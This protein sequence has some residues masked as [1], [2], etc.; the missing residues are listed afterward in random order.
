MQNRSHFA[1]RLHHSATSLLIAAVLVSALC[2]SARGQDDA[3]LPDKLTEPQKQELDFF[4]K[5]LKDKATPPDRRIEAA[6]LL[7]G[8][9]WKQAED[10]L[11]EVLADP[12]EA[13]AGG[14]LAVLEALASS[15]LNGNH[16]RALD[17]FIEPLIAALGSKEAAVQRAAARA[18]VIYKGKE[19][20]LDRLKKLVLSPDQP[21]A[22]RRGIVTAFSLM[23][24]TQSSVRPLIQLL[25][26][27]DAGLRDLSVSALDQLI[28]IG[29]G[30][31]VD[32]WKTWWQANRYNSPIEWVNARLQYLGHQTHE[33]RKQAQ[34]LEKRLVESLR[35]YYLITPQGQKHDRVLGFL[36][37]P[38][39][40]VR[41]LGLQLL[42]QMIG[43][44]E[45]IPDPLKKPAIDRLTDDSPRVRAAAADVA[46]YL[47]EP[48]MDEL[49]MAQLTDEVDPDAR[50]MQV[51]ALGRLRT[52]SAVPLL[53]KLLN[54][55]ADLA[56]AAESA[57]ALGSI[58]ARGR[59]DDPGIVKSVTDA[60][61]AR[62]KSADVRRVALREAI[63]GAMASIA[64]AA[65]GP[66]L[67]TALTDESAAVRMAAVRG[68]GNMQYD[69]AGRAR[70]V[71]ALVTRLGAEPDRGVRLALLAS[72]GRMGPGR[73][74][75]DAIY[76][77]TNSTT[78]A[79]EAVR[80]GAWETLLSLLKSADKATQLS[81]V[82]Q[83]AASK[84]PAAAAALLQLL[85]FA[86][87]KSRSENWPR[88]DRLAVAEQ[89]ADLLL[90]A[91]RPADAGSRFEQVYQEL[92]RSK[93]ARAGVVAE[94]WFKSLLADGKTDRAIALWK[95]LRGEGVDDNA[96]ADAMVDHIAGKLNNAGSADPAAARKL[97]V[98][99][100][101]QIPDAD[102]APWAAKIKEL[103]ERAD[104]VAAEQLAARV[105][106]Q[107]DRMVGADA[108]AAAD[109]RK[110]MTDMGTAA[111]PALLDELAAAIDI[112]D[113]KARDREKAIVA[114]LKA[115]PIKADGYDPAAPA[116]KKKQRLAAYRQRW[117]E[118]NK[119]SEL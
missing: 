42:D 82:R 72:I 27:Q 29:L 31:D 47:A 96:L 14:Q 46:P 57:N 119:P 19:D 8:K 52:P 3:D 61:V 45:K 109:A 85:T 22:L 106:T 35:Q 24:P 38:L 79:D 78:E 51:R 87:A 107:L 73:R 101:G 66:I 13:G 115:D 56:V 98:A 65:F 94:K 41:V 5:T 83:L 99:V 58:A 25:D 77:R 55:E 37:D 20:V 104:R 60:L 97:I 18:T 75:L 43:Q 113:P 44:G 39:P 64:E 95:R 6:T 32:A 92:A 48:K 91:G 86:E 36:T 4:T 74:Q 70:V 105:R 15:S 23:P 2:A 103:A 90:A 112:P 17:R 49:L 71:E 11:V 9:G 117:A 89:L 63:I 81:W 10:V 21:M 102:S 80:K 116:D 88:T 33:L 30:K 93:D 108:A 62:Y 12:G 67:R 59:I 100:G 68:L 111:V 28:P 84:E 1:G 40:A 34:Q 26:D 53:I 110:K 118:F 114:L 69:S 7:L 76:L 50:A 16:K 54:T